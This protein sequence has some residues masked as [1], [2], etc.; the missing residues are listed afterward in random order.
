MI[1]TPWLTLHAAESDSAEVNALGYEALTPAVLEQEKAASYIEALNFAYSQPDI[2]NVAVTGPYGAGKSSVLKTWCQAKEGALR[3]LTVSL[4]DF[5]MQKSVSEKED[6]LEKGKSEEVEKNA[7][8]SEKS[9]E[10]SILQQILYKNKKN[11]LPYSR[12]ERISGVTAGQILKSAAL[13]T[14]TMMLAGVALFFLAPDYITAKLSLPVALSQKLLVWPFS[15]RLIGAVLSVLGSLS[16][17]LYQLHRTGIFDRK[18]SLDKVD[19]LKGAVTTKSSSPSLLNVYID[20]I[21]YFFDSTKYDVVIFEDL[22][23]LNNNRI[24]IKLREINQ[25]INN[26]LSDRNPLKFIYAV[27]DDLFSSAE[28]RTKFFDF[29]I[30]VIPVMDKDNASDHFSNKFTKEER[31]QKGLDECISRIATFIPDMR[32]MHNITNEF[33]LY[34]NIVNNRENTPKLLAMIAYKNLCAEDYHSIDKK[35]GIVFHFMDAY[36]DRFIHQRYVKDINAQ[37]SLEQ[38]QLNS[39]NSEKNTYRGALR[40]E[41]L[42]PYISEVYREKLSF[43]NGSIL[44]LKHILD[45]EDDFVKLLNSEGFSII[46]SFRHHNILQV[47][48]NEVSS[49]RTAY[50]ERCEL[51]EKKTDASILRLKNNIALLETEKRSIRAESVSGIINRMQKSGFRS[52]VV[53]HVND[54]KELTPRQN[55]Q[56]DFVYFLLSSGYLSTDYM[57]FRSV[58]MPGVLTENDNIFIKSVMAGNDAG[59]S[60]TIPLQNTPNVVARLKKLAVIERENAQHP[61]IIHWL[62]DN[63]PET[64]KENTAALLGQSGGERAIKLL[65]LIQREFS[66]ELRLRYCEIFMQDEKLLRKLLTY[67]SE[68]EPQ[69]FVQEMTSLMLCLNKYKNAWLNDDIYELAEGII[70]GSASLIEFVPESHTEMFSDTLISNRFLVSNIPVVATE[71]HRALVTHLVSK[72]LFSYSAENLQNIYLLL[73]QSKDGLDF[74][75]RPLQCLESLSFPELK[76]VINKNIDA[77]VSDLFVTSDEFDRIPELLSSHLMMLSTAELIINRM[78]FCID[79]IASIENQAELSPRDPAAPEINT[80]SLLLSHDRIS[81]SLDNFVHLLHDNMIDIPYDLVRWANAKHHMLKPANIVISSGHVFDTFLKKFI[82]SPDLSEDTLRR[83][84]NCFSVLIMEIPKNIPIRN[85]EVLCS[86]N[87]LAPTI[88]VFTAL[89]NALSGEDNNLNRMNTLLCNHLARRPELLSAEPEEIFYIDDSFDRDLARELFGNG[90]IGMNIKVGT[91]RW[92]RDNDPD[93]MDEVQL[94][95]L[96]LLAELSPWMYDD[97]LRLS[98]L[99]SCLAAGD[100]DKNMLHN[101]LNS[102][103]DENY[104]G[105]LPNERYRKMTHTAE[106]WELAEQLSEAGLIQPPKMGTGRD[107]HKMVINPVRSDSDPAT[108]G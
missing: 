3:V 20:E 43:Y 70:S 59:E 11:E 49:L 90:H 88:Q 107:E 87:K 34:Q 16:L 36:V 73:S 5:D 2:R 79:N 84:M 91:L 67:L 7:E 97:T 103:A 22:D 25:I 82:A 40:K 98:L 32:V 78:E 58:F 83:V 33:R 75:R 15:A 24:F 44:S 65:A 95:P 4:A 62:L 76:N 63:A 92:L 23:R 28:S 41:L 64:L 86:L 48:V 52:W 9:I 68:S 105:L 35:G 99:K 42:S 66:T 18:V 77:F 6:Q 29:V 50:E 51:I 10:Y 45:D 101:V 60:F 55:E 53:Q 39:I 108:E 27:R 12:I 17:L 47:G 57:S 61:D 96:D 71:E 19:I 69:E 102:F 72:G 104:H 37:I 38:N 31:K 21:V 106:L 94:L 85:A 56:L 13:L 89:Y 100:A 1:P 8:T 80:Y 30:P 54:G 26:C 14:L 93:L 74:A 46:D 81:P